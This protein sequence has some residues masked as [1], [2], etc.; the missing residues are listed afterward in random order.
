LARKVRL[1]F[2]NIANH[3]VVKGINQEKIF[4]DES[5]F[6][7]Y[8]NLLEEISKNLYVSI[9]SYSL[10]PNYIHLL[11]TFEDKDS[12]ARFMQSLGLKYVSY[13]NKKYK[14]SG[15][16]WEGRY[17]SSLVEDK[18][19][20][21][22]M[23]YIETISHARYS[24]HINNSQDISDKTIKEHDMYTFLGKDEQDRA[25]LYKKHFINNPLKRDIKNFIEENLNK[26]SI[27]GSLEFYKKL[28][29]LVGEP[30]VAKKRGRPKKKSNDKKT[31]TR[32]EMFTKLVVLDRKEHKSLKVSPLENLKF[33][34]D[35][36][37]VPIIISEVA[38]I[39]EMFPVVFSANEKSSLVTLT[40]LGGVNLAINSD[41]KY[42]TKH[43]PAYLRKYPFSFANTKDNKEKKIV[44]IDEQASCVSK[45][46]GKQLF[47][48]DG[49]Q[50]ELLDNA[51]KF[52]VEY[53]KQEVV[54]KSMI[55]AIREQNVLEDR[56]ISIG[57]G[58]DKKVLVSGFQVVS[59][60][61][62]NKLDDKI[63]ASWVR[64]GIISFIDLHLKSLSKIDVLFK[65]AN[66]TK[67]S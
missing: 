65:L 12:Q 42:I 54:T 40:S 30:L 9:H 3:I 52:L 36:A 35:L 44:L 34:K 22:V 64:R 2:D 38:E 32:K 17:K 5:D 28:E 50:S 51:I 13:Y 47:T 16:I 1:F 59:K 26:Q 41:G 49:N 23:R 18:F 21:S 20:L 58:E 39:V 61:K 31:N 48:K 15:T 53:E 25:Q 27:T 45:S 37:F 62:L 24:S 14:R 66:Q 19:I 8:K 46:K 63:L 67:Q 11:C 56:E 33:A 7:F 55:K 4:R 60:E 6:L 43:V 57:E 29:A 10:M